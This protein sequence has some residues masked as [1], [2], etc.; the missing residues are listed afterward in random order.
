MWRGA[1][2]NIG[3]R[4]GKQG[5]NQRKNTRIDWKNEEKERKEVDRKQ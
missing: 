1:K 2:W 5:I 4:G 3:Q